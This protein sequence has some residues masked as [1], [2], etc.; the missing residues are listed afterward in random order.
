M[1]QNDKSA[2]FIS[3]VCAIIYVILE[4]ERRVQVPSLAPL[5]IGV[6]SLLDF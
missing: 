2:E 1:T 3:R 6:F 4:Y 5:F